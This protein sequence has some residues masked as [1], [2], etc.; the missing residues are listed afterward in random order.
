MDT[1]KMIRKSLSLLILFLAQFAFGQKITIQGSDTLILLGQRLSQ[2]YKRHDR[3]LDFAVKGGGAT[4][5]FASLGSGVDIAQDDTNAN[6]RQFQVAVAVQGIAVY[7]NKN[8]PVNALTLAQ[9]RSIFL[10]EIT[11]WRVLGGPDAPIVLFAGESTTGILD[12]FQERVLQ[13]KEPYPFVGKSNAKDLA[14]TIAATPNGIDYSSLR[15]SPEVKTIAIKL[16]PSSLAIGPSSETI[17]NRTYPISRYIYWTLAKQPSGNLS[18]FCSW[19]M[20]QEG[21][22]VVESVGFEPLLTR[23]RQRALANLGLNKTEVVA[24]K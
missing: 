20:S 3:G 14:D 8:N 6:K 18:E 7:V 24:G 1:T 13:G 22:T 9:L 16:G 11:N 10:G 15:Y 12:Y 17:R 2:Q 21:Q 4:P 23:D 19:V 5:A